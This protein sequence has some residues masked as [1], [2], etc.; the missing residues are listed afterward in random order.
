[1]VGVY[2]AI[3]IAGNRCSIRLTEWA[4]R[5]ENAVEYEREQKR[6][7]PRLYG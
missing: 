2:H 3:C 4:P 6:Y 7:R 1:M 5:K